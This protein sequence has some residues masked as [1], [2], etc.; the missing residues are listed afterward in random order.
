[1]NETYPSIMLRT[2]EI[3]T[4]RGFATTNEFRLAAKFTGWSTANEYMDDTV[5]RI[6]RDSLARICQA[7]SCTLADLIYVYE[8]TPT[9]PTL[10]LGAPVVGTRSLD[11]RIKTRAQEYGFQTAGALA[12]SAG[13][14]RDTA[15]YLWRGNWEYLDRKR[16]LPRLYKVL[17]CTSITDLITLRVE[18]GHA[19]TARPHDEPSYIAA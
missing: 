8:G 13:I 11:I 6:N 17:Q 19:Q 7:L 3:A 16:S 18:I 4:L 5:V 14:A 15:L 1:M 2:R 9:P 12:A 10:R